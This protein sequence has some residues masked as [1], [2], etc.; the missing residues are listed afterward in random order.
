MKGVGFEFGGMTTLTYN[1]F[2]LGGWDLM[3]CV[4]GTQYDFEPGLHDF[5]CEHRWCDVECKILKLKKE[6]YVTWNGLTK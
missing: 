1:A 6:V 3:E 2:I 4:C 5:I